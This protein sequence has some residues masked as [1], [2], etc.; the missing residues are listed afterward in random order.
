MVRRETP[1]IGRR[2]GMIAVGLTVGLLSASSSFAQA[3]A[4]AAPPAQAAPVAN[5]R[6]FPNDAAVWL[7]FIKPDKVTDF[8]MVIAKLKE[9]LSKSDKP[10]RKQ[11]LEGWK[12]YKSPDPAG[13]NTLFVMII[14]PVKGADYSIGNIISETFP[15]AEA[16][17]IL[18]AYASAYASPAMNIVNLNAIP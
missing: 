13:A 5:Q 18:T 11:Q 4:A 17:T 9:G 7:H 16:N 10:E 3:P 1:A 6:T 2:L 8:E 15:P 12:I 14:T